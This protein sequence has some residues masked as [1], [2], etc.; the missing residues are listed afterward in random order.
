[1]ELTEY[2]QDEHEKRKYE[3]EGD[4]LSN[5]EGGEEEDVINMK[6]I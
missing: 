1:M 6:A 2:N 4:H 5:E 3:T